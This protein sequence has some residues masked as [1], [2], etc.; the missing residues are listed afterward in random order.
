MDTNAKLQALER[1]Y[2]VFGDFAAGLNTACGPGC[3]ACCT[4]NV[5][6]TTLEARFLIDRA[7]VGN[8]S[9]S[10]SDPQGIGNDG[11]KTPVRVERT[12]IERRDALESVSI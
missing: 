3:S 8:N 4:A 6:V 12:A 2:A 9:S 10:L 5:V 7:S 1:I 11:W